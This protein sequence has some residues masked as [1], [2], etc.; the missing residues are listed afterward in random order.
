MAALSEEQKREAIAGDLQVPDVNS[1]D[2]VKHLEFWIV[3]LTQNL[4]DMELRSKVQDKEQKV[5]ELFARMTSM[6]ESQDNN[7]ASQNGGH[8]GQS[9][10]TGGQ[11]P[12]SQ[13][14][15][16]RDMVL[17]SDGDLSKLYP[18]A[19][20]EGANWDCMTFRDFTLGLWRVSIY[21]EELNVPSLMHKR[22]AEFMMQ[23]ASANCYTTEAFL[24]YD[25]H[26]S[27]VVI[28]GKLQDWLPSHNHA[29]NLYFSRVYTYELVNARKKSVGGK[30][31]QV[32]S[33]A[34]WSD[35]WPNG[36][37]YCYN[38]RMCNR[39]R[40]NNCHECVECGGGGGGPQSNGLYKK[41][42]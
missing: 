17:Q 19:H 13:W 26:V 7:Q 14:A 9:K 32:Y 8:T 41:P 6:E 3:T 28:E 11:S 36:V 2:Y 37:C 20:I 4:H 10:H 40:C 30:S 25:R 1:P 21:L 39:S 42:C 18:S 5:F 23:M 12:G 31:G 22:H 15:S 16:V 35:N 24:R 29:Q 27:T 34:W 38:W 33:K